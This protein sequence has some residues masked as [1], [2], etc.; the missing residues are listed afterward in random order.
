MRPPAAGAKL[1]IGENLYMYGDVD[2][3]IH[4]DLPV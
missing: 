4:E 1:V 3:P 2:G